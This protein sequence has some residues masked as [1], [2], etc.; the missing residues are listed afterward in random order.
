[1]PRWPHGRAF[2]SEAEAEDQQAEQARS[3]ATPRE[4]AS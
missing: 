1:M 3:C 4:Q 2:D